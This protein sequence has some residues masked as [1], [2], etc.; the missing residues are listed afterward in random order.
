MTLDSYYVSALVFWVAIFSLLEYTVQ[1]T[2][3]VI[4]S[5]SGHSVTLK[6]HFYENFCEKLSLKTKTKARHTI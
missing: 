5:C 4:N 3:I 1:Y 6:E 2:L